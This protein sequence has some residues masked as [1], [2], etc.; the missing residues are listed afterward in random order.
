MDVNIPTN[1]ELVKSGSLLYCKSST[2]GTLTMNCPEFL[3]V[4]FQ[5]F[6]TCYYVLLV[7][8]WFS[9]ICLTCAEVSECRSQI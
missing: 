8:S 9:Y 3:S 5:L 4:E 7:F 6:V 1:C 2:E